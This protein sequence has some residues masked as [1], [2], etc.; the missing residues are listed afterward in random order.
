MR[1]AKQGTFDGLCGVYAV[2]NAL[3]PA[4]LRQPRGKL[5]KDLFI[6]LTHALPASRLRAAMDYGLTVED[7]QK[8]AMG[9]FRWLRGAKGVSLTIRRPFR[10]HEFANLSDYLTVLSHAT[11]AGDAGFIIRIRTSSFAHWTVVTEVAAHALV[12]RDST[13]WS[14]IGR[15]RL[16]GGSCRIYPADTLVIERL[17]VLCT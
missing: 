14:E 8:A 11:A 10:Q 6:Q 1:P 7:I 17:P 4:G 13:G 16:D 5:H 12:L 3:D 9:A 15:H 2:L